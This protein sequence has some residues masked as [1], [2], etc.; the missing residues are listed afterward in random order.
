M[1]FDIGAV[2]GDMADAVRNA[3]SDDSGK[4]GEYAKRVMENERE[5]LEELAQAGLS[6]E[7]S[8]DEFNEEV[9]RE[10]K[11]IEAGLLTLEIMTKAMAQKAVNS[12]ID[13][14]VKAVK[15]AI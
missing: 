13:V 15:L 10:K 9:E 14:F 5:A 4:V 8:E 3:V 1:S 2:L 12:A 6:G 7:I 11:V